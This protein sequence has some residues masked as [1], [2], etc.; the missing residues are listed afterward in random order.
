MRLIKLPNDFHQ[1]VADTLEVITY[2]T[3]AQRALLDLRGNHQAT[4][5]VQRGKFRYAI[6]VVIDE[7]GYTVPTADSIIEFINEH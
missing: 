4:V 2:H 6:N 1:E 5:H 3:N 7:K